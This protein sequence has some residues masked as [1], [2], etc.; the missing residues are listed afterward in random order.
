MAI[1]DPDS[2][3]VIG[4]RF[5]PLVPRTETLD[6]GSSIG[7][8]FTA[9]GSGGQCPVWLRL[10]SPTPP[11]GVPT[12]QSI[13]CHL[14]RGDDPASAALPARR[15]VIPASA[16]FDD[17]NMSLGGGA[18]S[19]Y[20]ALA[21][22]SDGKYVRLAGGVATFVDVKFSI[23]LASVWS[24]IGFDKH[25]LDVTAL[26]AVSGPFSGQV[27]P[28]SFWLFE[29]GEVVEYLMDS[30]ISG[31]ATP[32]DTVTI[33]RSRLGELNPFW[34][35]GIDPTTNPHRMPWVFQS[36]DDTFV[37][38]DRAGL[39]GFSYGFGAGTLNLRV[40]ATGTGNFDL[41]YMAL[42]VTYRPI[43]D[44]I[45]C[46]GLDLSGGVSQSGDTFVYTIPIL[47]YPQLRNAATH[48]WLPELVA[49]ERYT[50]VV[51]KATTG[52]GS[53]PAATP[54]TLVPLASPVPLPITGIDMLTNLPDLGG[55]RVTRPVAIRSVPKSEERT[56]APAMVWHAARVAEISPTSS[57]VGGDAS[58]FDE[59]SIG[60]VNL[61]SEGH[62]YHTPFV[63]TVSA[64]VPAFA[65]AMVLDDT[66]ATCVWAS[67]YARRSDDTIADLTIYQSTDPAVDDPPVAIGP[68]GT[69]TV[70]AADAFTEIVDGWRLVTVA[71]DPAV[72]SMAAGGALWFTFTST[73]PAASPW[74]IAG[75]GADT[76]AP[77]GYGGEVAFAWIDNPTYGGSDELHDVDLTLFLTAELDQVTGLATTLA[78]QTLTVSSCPCDPL[79]PD[80]PGHAT[81]PMVPTGILY[82][83][84]D[85]D[86]V[87]TGYGPGFGYY[88]VQ[89]S[90]TSMALGAWETIATIRDQATTM[91]DDY[92]ARVGILTSYRARM[93]HRNGVS[94][95]WS[96]E[97]TVTI[98]APGVT[99]ECVDTGLLIMTSDT[100]PLLNTAVVILG[101]GEEF[102]M[103][104]SAWTAIDPIYGRDYQLAR[105]PT[106]RGGVRFTR[107]CVVN[108]VCV[109][110]ASMDKGFTS[111][112]DLA[113]A[114]LPYVCVR[115]EL[116]NRWLAN[117]T[118][119]KGAVRRHDH[120]HQEIAEIVITE[121]TATPATIDVEIVAS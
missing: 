74:E 41:Q 49:G 54:A 89:R 35:Y 100:D 68:T 73:T 94:G 18:G 120:G 11:P 107:S 43:G 63:A 24:Q 90:D 70:V 110:A 98:P 66:A 45:G 97:A 76:F 119:P 101:V 118:I 65:V 95:A 26:Y 6:T 96:T 91:F 15:I 50:I 102:G 85:W 116:G 108:T 57:L 7:Y 69:L 84:L 115:D 61:S 104:E 77:T 38:A 13:V 1:Y 60:D 83:Q 106:E 82:V 23:N 99:G 3:I 112:R 17:N 58:P 28:V 12:G 47:A 10:L 56:F 21:N 105:W 72:V 88:E 42:E 20:D 81:Q 86:P 52:A 59:A 78:T 92:E 4:S 111:L 25:I 39:Y 16:G 121:V 30:T 9:L 27:S 2:P 80:V 109:P 34:F 22:P 117:V 75:A 64:G 19:V 48:A 114:R 51:G 67:F 32:G 55:M 8:T 36:L 14:Y 33:G 79:T 53:Y 29:S 87:P 113:W 44:L 31:G 62:P 93:V 40:Y 103:V 46:G 71:L 5:E 37:D